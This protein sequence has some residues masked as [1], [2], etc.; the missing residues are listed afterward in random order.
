V[1]HHLFQEEL[2]FG[3]TWG[4]R[5]GGGKGPGRGFMSSI[6]VSLPSTLLPPFEIFGGEGVVGEKETHTRYLP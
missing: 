5:S 3:W 1:F 4:V 2:I 6:A